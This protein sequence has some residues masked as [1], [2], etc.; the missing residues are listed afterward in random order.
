MDSDFKNVLFLNT[1]RFELFVTLSL[2]R[3]NDHYKSKLLFTV[4]DIYSICL[5]GMANRLKATCFK[6]DVI[7]FAFQHISGTVSSCRRLGSGSNARRKNQKKR[8]RKR[9]L[10][11]KIVQ[12]HNA[13]FGDNNFVMTNNL[14]AQ[15]TEEVYTNERIYTY[16]PRLVR[17]QL[18][19]AREHLAFRLHDFEFFI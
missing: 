19:F 18:D 5:Y 3:L 10:A 4:I 7:V 9:Q 2:S 13:D 8:T 17:M 16:A 6:N 12:Q 15:Q 14:D 11:S 1:R